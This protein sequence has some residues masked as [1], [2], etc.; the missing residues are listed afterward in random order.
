MA[1]IVISTI[2]AAPIEELYEHITGFGRDG[3]IDEQ[4][5][6][7]KYG[8][9]TERQESTFVV[10]EDARANPEDEPDLVTWRCEF[11]YPTIRSMEAV[12]STWANRSDTF[13][14]VSGGTRWSVRWDTRLGG[15]LGIAQHL[16]FRAFGHRRIKRETF[17]PV[18]EHFEAGRTS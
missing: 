11:N 10:R 5:F 6:E 9:V 2:I 14:S 13:H 8:T 16:V 15:M 4:A 12:D 7:E 17:G 3:P 1:I 18:R